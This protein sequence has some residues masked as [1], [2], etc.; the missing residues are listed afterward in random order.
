MAGNGIFSGKGSRS[1]W[2]LGVSVLSGA[3]FWK[4]SPW[5]SAAA[6]A[7]PPAAPAVAKPALTVATATLQPAEWNQSLTANGSVTA[8]QEA[9]IGAEITGVRIVEVHVNVGDRVAKGQTLASLQVDTAQA[10]EA[11]SQALLQEN[12]ALLAEASANAQR[13][14]KLREV[15][16]VSAQQVEQAVN[17]EKAARARLDVQRARH[18]ASALRLSQVA[19]RSPDAGVISARSAT[20]GTLTQPGMELFRLIRQGRL[21]WRAELTADELVQIRP[22]MDV[23]VIAAQGRTVHGKV[24]A[25]APAINPQTRYGQVLVDLPANSGLVAGMF[26]RGT[27]HL[28]QQAGSLL[29]QSAVMSRDGGA[30]VLVVDQQ[31]RV[32]ERKV[33]TGRRQRDQIE[34]VSGLAQDE[35][36]VQVGGA[37]LVE[38]DAVRVTGARK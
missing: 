20:V 36:V 2:L 8:W 6:H 11:E 13:M 9:S 34:V 27:F 17:N 26:A 33:V 24:R 29:P 19:I 28:G 38:G 23:E 32:H 12:E 4:L 22:G 5:F 35:P 7:V 25:V 10:N 1:K 16:F 30:Y 21:E 18:Q 15:G 31:S 14:R 3:L 37:F